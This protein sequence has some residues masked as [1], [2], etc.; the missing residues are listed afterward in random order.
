MADASFCMKY[1]Q[2]TE[3]CVVFGLYV[4]QVSTRNKTHI[5]PGPME[6]III[7]ILYCRKYLPDFRYAESNF[8]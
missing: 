1:L 8:Y 6:Y 7:I 2:L 3:Q 5:L 4:P